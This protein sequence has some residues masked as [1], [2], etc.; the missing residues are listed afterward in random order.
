MVQLLLLAGK[1][2]P[3]IAQVKLKDMSELHYCFKVSVTQNFETGG[4]LIGQL[5]YTQGIPKK[6]GLEHSNSITAPEQ[7]Y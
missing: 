2:E 4:M 5:P 7:G 1:S 6:F 3:N